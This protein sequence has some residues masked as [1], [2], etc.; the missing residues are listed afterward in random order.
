MLGR[1]HVG[2]ENLGKVGDLGLAQFFRGIALENLGKWND[3]AEAFGNAAKAGYDPKSS[4]LHRAGALRR[5]GKPTSAGRSWKA[6][7]S[8]RATPPSF[9]TRREVSSRPAG[10]FKPPRSNSRRRSRPTATTTALCLNS[11][12]SMTC[13]ATTTRP[14]NTTSVVR[15]ARRCLW[16]R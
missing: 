16:R 10:N 13:T 2:L 15:C 4:E 12:T 1:Y 5:A 11:R 9:T 8:N 3:A 7:K 14:S 6:W